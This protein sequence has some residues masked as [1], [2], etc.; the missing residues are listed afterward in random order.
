[1]RMT[2]IAISAC[3]GIAPTDTGNNTKGK[4][5]KQF[6][7]EIANRELNISICAG[8][9][10]T[11]EAATTHAQRSVDGM[12]DKNWGTAK[13]YA[14]ELGEPVQVVYSTHTAK[15]AKDRAAE[16]AF[17]AEYENAP[18]VTMYDLPVSTEE[19]MQRR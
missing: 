8:M 16:R 2:T 10:H 7:I 5:M 4:T 17:Y 15:E 13:I 6:I 9:E 1:M 19:T 18:A 11:L 12:S 3:A 14:V